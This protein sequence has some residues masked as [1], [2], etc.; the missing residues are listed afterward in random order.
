LV[1]G[2]P[3]RFGAARL[4]FALVKMALFLAAML[5][6]AIGIGSFRLPADRQASGI[7]PVLPALCISALGQA[8]AL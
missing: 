7:R 6:F 4:T 5:S 1:N 8:A 2:K 3:E